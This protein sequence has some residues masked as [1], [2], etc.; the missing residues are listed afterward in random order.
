MDS[1]LVLA[2]L[3]GVLLGRGTLRGGDRPRVRLSVPNEGARGLLEDLARLGVSPS[4]RRGKR[5]TSVESRDARLLSALAMV[6]ASS[7][8]VGRMPGWV[9]EDPGAARE[10][11]SGLYSVR[12]EVLGFDGSRPRPVRLELRARADREG[13]LLFLALDVLRLLNSLGVNAEAVGLSPAS[14]GR[15]RYARMEVL[16]R[17]RRDLLRFLSR[18][19]FRYN[20]REEERAQLVLEELARREARL[21]ARWP[22][23]WN[24]AASLAGDRGA[25]VTLRTGLG[26]E[27]AG[28]GDLRVPT[29]RGERRL[30]DLGPGDRVVLYPVEVPPAVSRR[31]VLLPDVGASE[32]ARGFLRD[33]GLLPLRWEDPVVPALARIVGYAVGDGH[34]ERDVVKFYGESAG[35][36]WLERDLGALGLSPV[37]YEYE[38]RDAVEVAVHSE[39]FAA[40]LRELGVPEGRKTG[41]VEVPEWVR[42]GPSRVVL[43]FLAGLFGA[44]GHVSISRSRVSVGLT[45]AS[46]V[47]APPGLFEGVNRLVEGELGVRMAVLRNR[48]Y[49][50]SEGERRWLFKMEL[51]GERAERFLT[52]VPFE[53]SLRKRARGLW[54]GAFLRYRARGGGSSFERFVRERCLPGGKVVDRVVSV[55][56]LARGR[57]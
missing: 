5:W 41:K 51:W 56:A 50:T 55:S 18:V 54:A 9:F 25:G 12:G 22:A 40:L 37:R 26:F 3:L 21:S 19:R 47:G 29:L 15:Y 17:G 42:Q 2:R 46:P 32:G 16:V 52:R 1:E 36:R 13:S 44:D 14:S 30:G 24:G 11:L 4:V 31:G 48:S 49:E 7:D 38:D 20:P 6:G 10:L 35:L 27:L 39:G 8:S 23:R 28:P 45:Q 33:L 34:L 53:Y 57:R 43:E